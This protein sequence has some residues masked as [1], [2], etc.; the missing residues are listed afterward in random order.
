MVVVPVNYS[1]AYN[2]SLYHGQRKSDGKD[3]WKDVRIS[4]QSENE[5]LYNEEHCEDK[6]SNYLCEPSC[7]TFSSI[8]SKEN[9]KLIDTMTSSLPNHYIKDLKPG[10][11]IFGNIGLVGWVII[12]TYLGLKNVKL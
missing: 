3:N 5:S 2:Y 1:I 11:I 6:A 12:K 4:F 10:S 8:K 9:I 7:P